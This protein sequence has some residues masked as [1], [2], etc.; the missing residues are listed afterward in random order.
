MPA[1]VTEKGTNIYE[2]L[3]ASFHGIR[4]FVLAYVVTAGVAKDEAGIKDNKSIFFQEEKSKIR[5]Y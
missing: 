5:M 3:N 1:I 2:L 4:L